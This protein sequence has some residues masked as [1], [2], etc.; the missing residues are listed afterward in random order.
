[1]FSTSLREKGVGRA[2]LP[3]NPVT[4]GVLRTTYQE[5][6]SSAMRTSRYPGN[7]F[8]CTTTLRP[9]LNSMTSSIGMTTS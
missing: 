7:T 2:P 4:P 8:F 3:T 1:M 6:S 5:S 9:P